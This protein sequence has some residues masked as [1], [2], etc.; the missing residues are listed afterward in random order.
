MKNWSHV[1]E[2]NYK[3]IAL[4]LFHLRYLHDHRTSFIFLSLGVFLLILRTYTGFYEI[5]CISNTS[6]FQLYSHGNCLFL[7]FI[8]LY[9][10]VWN[11]K[12]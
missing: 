7:N 6:L 10:S 8:C 2:R 12:H 11:L 5:I 9:S 1:S 3:Y 4:N